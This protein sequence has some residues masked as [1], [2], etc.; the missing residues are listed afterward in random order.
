MT[1]YSS[2][3]ISYTVGINIAKYTC[4]FNMVYLYVANIH[5]LIDA[6]MFTI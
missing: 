3:E 2:K 5:K 6:Y 1:T 4:I